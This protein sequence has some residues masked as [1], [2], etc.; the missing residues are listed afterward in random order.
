MDPIRVPSPAE[1]AALSGAELD[2]ALVELESARRRLEAAYVALVDRAET[3]KRYAPDG[4]ASVRGWV[5]ALTDSSPTEIQRRLQTMRALRDLPDVAAALADGRV[6]VEHVREIAKV[7]ANPRMHEMVVEGDDR[8]LRHAHRGFAHLSDVLTRWVQ[9]GDPDG[10]KRRQRS[11]DHER[12]ANVFH[13]DGTVRIHAHC[14]T[15]Q[16]AAIMEIFQRQCDAEFLTDWEAARAA[17]GADAHTG[18]LARTDAQRRMDALHHLLEQAVAVPADAKLPD[19]VVDYVITH[20]VYD[21]ELAALA[22]GTWAEAATIDDV[23]SRRCE[24]STGIPL[25][26]REV[27]LASL[28]GHI[29]RLVIDADRRVIDMGRKRRF[30]GGARDA[31]FLGEGR[32]CIW[33]GCGRNSHRNQ[34]DHTRDHAHG[35]LT[36]PDNGGPACG[37]HNRHKNRGYTVRR[38]PDG[39]W[40]TYRPDGTELTE[41]AA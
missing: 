33:P 11:A 6:G 7:H 40:H 23:D 36:R 25:D 28:Q 22:T 2:R 10:W 14:G 9:F 4:H 15:V 1:L 38:D 34:V 27:V 39:T 26:P 41:P 12:D 20:D 37:R 8:L 21:A 13:K 31:V 18:H 3:T 32:R 29:R 5:L 24:T 30:T 16:G 17:H 35:G 19:P